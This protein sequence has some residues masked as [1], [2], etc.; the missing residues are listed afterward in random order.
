MPVGDQITVK[1]HNFVKSIAKDIQAELKKKGY[2]I[3]EIALY[4]IMAKELN[5][6]HKTP[7]T[8]SNLHKTICKFV[9]TTAAT[10]P[11]RLNHSNP[12]LVTVLVTGPFGYK[13]RRL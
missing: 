9:A 2:G 10:A 12:S 13:A 3:T 7:T 5:E 8:K 11:R 6:C 1:I 4:D